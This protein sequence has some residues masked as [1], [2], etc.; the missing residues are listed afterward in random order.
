MSQAE[1]HTLSLSNTHTHTH[2]HTHTVSQP[3]RS[4]VGLVLRSHL[5]LV[6]LPPAGDGIPDTLT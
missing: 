1:T 2:S 5:V 3:A 4:E 6:L